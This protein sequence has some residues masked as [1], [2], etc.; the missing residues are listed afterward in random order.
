[1]AFATYQ[2]VEVAL[3]RVL[4]TAAQKAQVT[5]WLDGVELLIGLRLGS[6]VALNQAVL[7]YVETEAVVAKVNRSGR[8]ESSVTVSVDDGSV[9]RRYESEMTADDITEAWW[10]MLAPTIS[11]SAYTIPMTSPLDVV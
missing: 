1:M 7:K 5:Y 6:V 4:S 9:T 8:D 10:S 3:G 2:D 11:G